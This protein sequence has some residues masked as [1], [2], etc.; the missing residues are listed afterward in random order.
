MG[1]SMFSGK[2]I[3]QDIKESQLN[4]QLKEFIDSIGFKI[5]KEKT[6]DD[7]IMLK[8]VNMTKTL[9]LLFD[10]ATFSGQEEDLQRIGIELDLA[11][12]DNGIELNLS[13]LPYMALMD[14]PEIPVLTQQ[15]FI[16]RETDRRASKKVFEKIIE[17]VQAKYAEQTLVYEDLST[18]PEN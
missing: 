5:V 14:R 1:E 2:F 4:D 3:I 10:R 11:P 17:K 18:E 13:V 8:A 6:K 9:G 7:K 12:A 15:L 16:E